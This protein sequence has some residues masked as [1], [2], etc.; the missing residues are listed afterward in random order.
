MFDTNPAIYVGDHKEHVEQEVYQII[1]V[2]EVVEVLGQD[3]T[4]TF[5]ELA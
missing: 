4:W 5:D 3:P 1:V 2:P